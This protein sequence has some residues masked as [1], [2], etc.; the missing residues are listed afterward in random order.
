MFFTTYPRQ[1]KPVATGSH[2]FFKGLRTL[3]ALHV[4]IMFVNLLMLP[5]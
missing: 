2:Q 4:N 1:Y 5:D 3:L